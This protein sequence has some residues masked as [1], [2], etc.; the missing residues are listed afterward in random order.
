MGIKFMCVFVFNVT[1]WHVSIVKV[2]IHCS[3]PFQGLGLQTGWNVCY[4]IRQIQNV[5]FKIAHIKFENPPEL[6]HLRMDEEYV[7]AD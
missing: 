2:R 3:N 1:F 4:T 5:F 6:N 7:V